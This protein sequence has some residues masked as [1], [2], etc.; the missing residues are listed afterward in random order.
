MFFCSCKYKKWS[1]FVV[2]LVLFFYFLNEVIIILQF[3]FYYI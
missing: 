1:L 2:K 3:N